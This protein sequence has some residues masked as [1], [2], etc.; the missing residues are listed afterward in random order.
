MAH[1]IIPATLPQAE[2]KGN[3]GC[4]EEEESKVEGT[5]RQIRITKHEIRNKS[6]IRIS[7]FRP[8]PFPVLP[9]AGSLAINRRMTGDIPRGGWGAALEGLRGRKRIGVLGPHECTPAEADLGFRVGA[10]LARR[11]AV[12]LCG[13][14]GGMMEAAARGAKSEGGLAVGL[15][16]GDDAAAA[17]PFIDL[18]LPT[19]LGAM[20][21]ALLVRA[22]DA[23]IAILGGVG[24][25][26][27][28]GFALRLGVP[29]VGLRTWKVS[30]GGAGTRLRRARS[31]EEAARRA[32]ALAGGGRAS[33]G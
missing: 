10:E 3:P 8:L 7:D 16:P 29:A 4:R 30:R 19:G 24:T 31:P 28:I 11:G 21:N 17:N 15:L 27:E 13:G 25:L 32:L 9:V 12:L 26:S 23:V 5:G 6:K 1:A 2:A 22:C 18:A 20:R 33:R 14:L